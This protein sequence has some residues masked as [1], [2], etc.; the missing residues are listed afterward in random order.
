MAF[1]AAVTLTS[2]EA[3]WSLEV[4]EAQQDQ[5]GGA[6]PAIC[7]HIIQREIAWNVASSLAPRAVA[8]VWIPRADEGF[9]RSASSG[10]GRRYEIQLCSPSSSAPRIGQSRRTLREC[11][12]GAQP[13]ARS[14][15]ITQSRCPERP[16]ISGFCRIRWPPV[17]PSRRV[18]RG[19]R[20]SRFV[21]EADRTVPLGPPSERIRRMWAR[22]SEVIRVTRAYRLFAPSSVPGRDRPSRAEGVYAC[23][24]ASA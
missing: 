15:R 14:S 1:T 4:C 10:Q 5:R 9:G 24:D 6:P 20:A 23:R 7:P 18:S 13:S 12:S 16:T 11:L 3:L 2:P 22:R 17:R 21:G 8:I 19:H